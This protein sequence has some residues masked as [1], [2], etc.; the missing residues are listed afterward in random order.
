MSNTLGALL[1]HFLGG[2][3][4]DTMGVGNMLLVCIGLS[5]VG[6]GIVFTTVRRG[7]TPAFT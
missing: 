7:K 3:L 6:M 5:A 4:I 2:V 1:A